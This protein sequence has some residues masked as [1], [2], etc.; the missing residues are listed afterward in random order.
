MFEADF[1]SLSQI[2]P[3]IDS[4]GTSLLWLFTPG[5]P[6][7][8]IKNDFGSP[9]QL[10][11]LSVAVAR[12]VLFVLFQMSLLTTMAFDAPLFA[13]RTPLSPPARAVGTVISP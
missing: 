3:R 11:S 5:R 12:L 2:S 1:F 8:R 13:T 4:E 10:P 9:R 7:G 6:R